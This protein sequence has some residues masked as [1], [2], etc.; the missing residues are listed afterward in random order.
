[1]LGKPF[2]SQRM[3]LP[4]A[5]AA[6]F[7]VPVFVLGSGA[8]WPPERIAAAALSPAAAG[9][10][11]RL[12]NRRIARGDYTFW[13]LPARPRPGQAVAVFG[14][15]RKPG[16]AVP[17][18]RMAAAGRIFKLE[19]LAGGGCRGVV[20]VPL[21]TRPGPWR[22]RLLAPGA[23]AAGLT[24]ELEVV[25]HDYGEQRLTLPPGMVTPTRPEVKA[26][27]KRDRA[28]LK[29]VY[30]SSGGRLLLREPLRPP[31]EHLVTSP[32]G[33]RRLLNGRSMAPHGGIDYRARVGVPVPAAGSGR[34]VLAENLYYSG[35]LVL[36]D[37]GLDI[38]TLYMHL[39]RFSCKP[40]QR[41]ARG[42]IIGWS[43]RSG[44]VTGPHLHWG[45]KIN[46]IFVDPLAF[47]RLSR[48]LLRPPWESRED[49]G[50]TVPGKGC[51]DA[52][53]MVI[54][55]GGAAERVVPGKP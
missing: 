41:V 15:C 9:S 44:R 35:N 3:R 52:G 8:G 23:A 40:G 17:F 10:A 13:L 5:L 48:R 54:V 14:R 11:E 49:S 46:G 12:Q 47:A 22:L 32:F 16:A 53:W 34:V 38:F 31:L 33:R 1:M 29:K 45:V 6:L 18:T 50:I 4:G 20:A 2:S 21:G 37:H 39:S 51:R 25:A 42:D 55:G 7:L 19:K 28:R 26:R 36:I 30:A 24:L 27:I 43:G